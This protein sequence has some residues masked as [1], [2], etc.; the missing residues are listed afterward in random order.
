MCGRLLVESGDGKVYFEFFDSQE[1]GWVLQLAPPKYQKRPKALRELAPTEAWTIHRVE[2]DALVHDRAYWTLVPP[3]IGE[4]LRTVPSSSGDLRLEP[5]PGTHFNSRKD[6]LIRSKDW[7]HLLERQRC[8]V[9]A[10]GFLEWS[11]A[12]MLRAT[13]GP[14]RVGKYQ[15]AQGKVMPLAGI[16]SSNGGILTFS[17]IT[18]EPN[19][20]LESLPHHR[21]P[22]I[23]QGEKVRAWLDPDNKHPE[24]CLVSTPDEE[25][26]SHVEP[27][28][29]ASS[30]KGKDSKRMQSREL[31]LFE[32]G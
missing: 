15:L 32:E 17:V 29:A 6:T 16:W 1:Q 30:R 28:K 11:D 31:D 13:K 5:P 14:K 2:N 24:D 9:L 22:A 19:G 21:M 27:V 8:L 20:L 26:E 3:W 12:E 4:P 18:C 23:L 25:F 7:K 10:S